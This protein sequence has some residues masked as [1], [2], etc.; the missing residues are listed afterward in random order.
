MACSRLLS[1]VVSNVGF[2]RI[3]NWAYD[4]DYK[5]IHAKSGVRLF[6]NSVI[7]LSNSVITAVILLRL[8]LNEIR[9][10]TR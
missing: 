1:T 5:I 6:W 7:N 3:D 2:G 8:N 9:K 4:S 10:E